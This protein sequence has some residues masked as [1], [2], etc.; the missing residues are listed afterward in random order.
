MADGGYDYDPNLGNTFYG[1]MPIRQPGAAGVVPGGGG[2][3]N[4][5]VTS[6]PM[7]FDAFGQPIVTA[8]ALLDP[9]NMS[10]EDRARMEQ[11]ILAGAPSP[12]GARSASPVVDLDLPSSGERWLMERAIVR[13]INP[14]IETVDASGEPRLKTDP[15]GRTTNPPGPRQPTPAEAEAQRQATARSVGTLPDRGKLA[16]RPDNVG[17]PGLGNYLSSGGSPVGTGGQRYADTS[18][19]LASPVSNITVSGG[20]GPAVAPGGGGFGIPEL[21]QILSAAFMPTSAVAS[22][23]STRPTPSAAEMQSRIIPEAQRAYDAGQG[24]YSPAPGIY[25]PTKTVSGG[26]RYSYGDKFSGG[27]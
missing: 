4:R 24:S 23:T 7:K 21:F 17:A 26:Q 3:V 2:I 1:G 8:P 14:R 20:R 11:Q 9:M 27:R 19:P 18:A 6:Q 15:K 10:V 16:T 22:E 25:M 5:G 13:G 12:S